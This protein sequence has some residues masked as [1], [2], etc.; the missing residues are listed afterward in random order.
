M[1]ERVESVLDEEAARLAAGNL[2]GNP[3]AWAIERDLLLA[4]FRAELTAEA[5]A[6]LAPLAVELSFGFPDSEADAFEVAVDDLGS[7]R[8]WGRIDRVDLAASG[9]IVTD[10]K[11]SRAATKP[12]ICRSDVRQ[13]SR[14]QL[15]LYARKVVG[16]HAA[17]LGAAARSADDRSLRVPPT[18]H[19]RHRRRQRRRSPRRSTSSCRT[20]PVGWRP[21][22]SA[23]ARP[24]TSGRRSSHPTVWASVTSPP[25]PACGTPRRLPRRR[26]APPRG[27]LMNA[28]AHP[29]L[30]R[31]P[32]RPRRRRQRRRRPRRHTAPEAAPA[33]ER[34]GGSRPDGRRRRRA[35]HRHRRGGL[36]KDHAA[37]RPGAQHAF[38]YRDHR[39][40][41]AI[42]GGRDHL[43]RQGRPRT[44]P[45]LARGGH[46][47]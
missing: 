31:S 18:R 8:F 37:R 34:S 28:A 39:A 12:S 26:T 10:F 14:L 9:V 15:P 44:G 19:Q 21:A 3:H 32:P 7:V 35:R 38:R 45:P 27:R 36:G 47:A 46:G 20:P 1:I 16:E 24:T 5:G 43:H 11:T 4:A 23:R 6:R 42:A 41:T 22:T 25:G 13:G 29:R 30:R 17:E 2:L 40:G 33:A